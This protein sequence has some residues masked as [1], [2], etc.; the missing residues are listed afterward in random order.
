MTPASPTGR[1]P[2]PG[3]STLPLPPLSAP[4]GGRAPLP[5]AAKYE[6]GRRKPPPPTTTPAAS[7]L[8]ELECASVALGSR[9]RATNIITQRDALARFVGTYCMSWAAGTPQG[10]LQLH[11]IGQRPSDAGPVDGVPV[12]GLRR[13]G[14]AEAGRHR[15]ARVAGA[16]APL[17]PRCNRRPRRGRPQ[18]RRDQTAWEACLA[19][20]PR[21]A[22]GPA[23]V[24]PPRASRVNG[25]GT[26]SVAPPVSPQRP[27]VVAA[28]PVYMI[29]PP[30]LGCA[31]CWGVPTPSVG[32]RVGGTAC[33]RFPLSFSL[34]SWNGCRRRRPPA[35]PLR[36]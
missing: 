34:F 9:A 5:A 4:V 28:R 6:R 21:P 24:L 11:L 15:Q 1:H 23:P 3:T 20:A 2:G 35:P 13:E 32:W 30:H 26:W 25:C 17:P 18:P 19:L 10:C 8:H 12:P 27:C 14:G 36:P 7:F 16:C 29:A 31:P 33:A 22:R